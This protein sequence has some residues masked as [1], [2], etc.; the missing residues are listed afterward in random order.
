VRRATVLAL[1]VAALVLA[2]PAHAAPFTPVID[3]SGLR[4]DTTGAALDAHDG[5]IRRFGDRYWLYGTSY[6]CGFEWQRPGSPFCG[7]RAY[8]SPDL[9]HW[10]DEGPLFDAATP[11][12]QSR[13][14]GASYGCYR[15][16][17][18]YNPQTR[19][20]VLWINAYDVPQ[21]YHVFESATPAGPFTERAVPHLAVNGGIPPGV[22]NGDHELFVDRDGSAYLVYTDWRRGGDIV[23]ERLDD[24]WLDGTGQFV[25]LDVR[26][27][28]APSMF[29]RGERYY[30]TLS[31]PNCGYCATGTSYLTADSPLG[32][33]HGTTVPD[34]W[35]VE[36]GRLLVDGGDIGLSRAGADWSDY[37][38]SF[39]TTPLG[40]GHGGAYAQ[41]GWVFRASDAGNGYAWLL[42]NY[43]HPGA[44]GGNL[45]RVV[46]RGG[47]VASVQVVKLPF[48]V[49][50]GHA[51][52]VETRLQGDH[53]TTVVDGQV[54]DETVDD[55]YAAGRV[56]FR[57]SGGDGESARFDDVRVTAPDGTVLLSDDFGGDL[58]AWDRPPQQQRGIRISGDSCGGQPADVADLPGR[59][60]HIYLFQSDLWNHGAPNEALATHHWE[61]LRFTADGAIEPLRC[62]ER[63]PVELAGA[64]R[65]ADRVTPDVDQ[66]SGD[67]GFAPYSDVAGGIERAQTFTAGR[68]GTLRRVAFTTHQAG[69]PAGPLVLRVTG[70]G[71]DGTPG[72]T[73]AERTVPAASIGWSP[74][75]VTIDP[76]VPV[77]GGHRYA[78]VISAPSAPPGGYGM[79]YS[80]RDPYAGGGALYSSDGGR[81]WRPESGRDLRF[82][83][84]VEG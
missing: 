54:V 23:V 31:D 1:A 18:A 29:R 48:A 22:N 2:A 46:L 6:D 56:G 44:E 59:G 41:S 9:V 12:W 4:F 19:R 8:S 45:T 81:T 38:L 72:A 33:W 3:N 70:V 77:V 66:T 51:Y 82:E 55:T 39:T 60:G 62:G 30:I 47:G 35:R 69:H 17:V 43:P 65:G 84:A 20:Y 16:H 49:E 13:C 42:G 27:T 76:D 68:T 61:P 50:A 71:A 75:P 24:R 36:D 74:A 14:D 63:Y 80:D 64:H 73:L 34:S 79:A 57:E 28:E 52:H 7:F 21:G 5:E 26:A 53:I 25:R 40:T 67:A 83:T 10:T 11:A 15:P 37:T 58:S 78:V 32:P